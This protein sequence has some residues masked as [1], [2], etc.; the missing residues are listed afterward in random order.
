MASLNTNVAAMA[1]LSTLRTIDG[2]MGKTQS[3]VSSGYRIGQAAD[4]AAYWSIATTMRS[5]H[6]AL[7][8]VQ[9]A[10]SL[11]AAMVD[12]TYNGMSATLDVVDE[13]KKRLVAA[14]EPGVDKLKINHEIDALK[15]Q[16]YSI[17]ESSSFSG[18]NW[19]YRIDV[20]DDA[21]KQIVGSFTRSASGG[22]S[23]QTITYT[24]AT[25]LGT[26]HLLDDS[27][28]NG[29]LTN[30][31]FARQLGT[32]TEWVLMNGK[33]HNIHPE[34]ALTTATTMADIDEMISVVDYMIGYMAD[35]ASSLGALSSRV[36]SQQDFV[37]ALR[38]AISSG[39]GRLVDADMNAASTRLK[40]LQTQQ[41]LSLQA[42]S[43]A[44]SEPE[45]LLQLFQ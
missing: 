28:H 36:S 43:I 1:A 7:S 5:D 24:M 19:L 37:S 26:K 25:P 6:K 44:N 14:R 42:L 23:V 33:N 2:A 12:V 27:Y 4:N 31:E 20:N 18:Q 8:A 35:A 21:D 11:G 39:V 34:I 22:V 40:A 29:I 16:I 10:L 15:A 30:V 3:Q 17:A 45:K 41:Q 32:A 9:D 38:D 13:I